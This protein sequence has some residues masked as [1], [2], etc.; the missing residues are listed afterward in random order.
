MDTLV[1]LIIEIEYLPCELS[2]MSDLLEEFFAKIIQPFAPPESLKFNPK[3]KQKNDQEVP[4]TL[5][6]P[7]QIISQYYEYVILF[8]FILKRSTKPTPK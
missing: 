8:S 3:K 1:G 2:G 5:Y 4:H 7:S 6:T